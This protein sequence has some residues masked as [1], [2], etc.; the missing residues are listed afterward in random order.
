MLCESGRGKSGK[1]HRRVMSGSRGE[2]SY[3]L[4][5]T[6]QGSRSRHG[7][8]FVWGS[9]LQLVLLALEAPEQIPS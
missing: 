3:L 6:S 5:D 2:T 9:L 7:I 8:I 1:I 4:L